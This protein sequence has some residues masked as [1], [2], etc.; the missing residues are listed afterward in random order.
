MKK[1]KKIISVL[2]IFTLIAGLVFLGINLGYIAYSS[3][4][5]YNSYDAIPSRHVGLVLGCRPNSGL[6]LQRLHAI[7]ELYQRGKIKFIIV[8]GAREEP[9]YMKNY[10]HEQFQIPLSSIQCDY[11]GFRTLDS[12]IRAEAIFSQTDYIIVTQFWHTPRALISAHAHKMND[13]IAFN[14]PSYRFFRYLRTPPREYLARILSF[15]D[16]FFINRQPKY[17]GEKI[18]IPR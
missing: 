11:A 2:L 8:S 15:I 4:F 10:L 14:A 5:C 1:T 3:S 12:I 6:L 7:A 13:V 18:E 16:L 9:E 17:Y